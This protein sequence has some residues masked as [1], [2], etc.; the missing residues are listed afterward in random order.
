M[1]RDGMGVVV[2][3]RYHRRRRVRVDEPDGQALERIPAPKPGETPQE[4]YK[5]LHQG[6]RLVTRLLGHGALLVALASRCYG[7]ARRCLSASARGAHDLAAQRRARPVRE[8]AAWSRSRRS[9][10]VYALV[11]HDFSV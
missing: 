5:T 3:G 4:M 7:V 11:T 10:M 9:S 6:S 1:F 8:F 2:E